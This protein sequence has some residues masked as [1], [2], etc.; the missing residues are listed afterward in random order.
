MVLNPQEV[1]LGGCAYPADGWTQKI[2]KAFFASR[3][4]RSLLSGSVVCF[5]RVFGCVVVRVL[6]V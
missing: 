1:E 4:R 6:C 3:N 2:R 5:V